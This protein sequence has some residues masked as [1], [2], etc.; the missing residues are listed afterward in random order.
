MR[1]LGFY[2]SISTIIIFLLA[3]LIPGFEVVDIFLTI[4]SCLI[5]G[6]TNFLILPMLALLRIKL[7]VAT[8]FF[9][10]LVINAT[11]LNMATG[12]IDNFN[13]HSWVAAIIGAIFLS[14]TQ[15]FAGALVNSDQLRKS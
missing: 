11:L 7:T 4:L 13:N 8:L 9:F 6:F 2:L 10:S 5:I 12:L 14:L 3:R 15:V 1:E